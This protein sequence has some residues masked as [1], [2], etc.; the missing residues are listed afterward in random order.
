M[1]IEI[2]MPALSPTMTEGK[3]AKWLVKEGD[4][5][6]SGDVIAE[7][8]TDKA[9]MEVEAVDEGTVAKILVPEGTD[10]VAVNT[11]IA[12]V[13]GEGE[14]ASAAAAPKAAP[15][16]AP[17]PVA[18][19][20]VAAAAPAPAAASAPAPAGARVF[21]SPLAKR[22]AKDSGVDL[23]A[24]R[25]SGPHGRIVK[26]DVEAAAMAPKPAPAAVAAAAPVAAPAPAPKPAVFP[27]P[28]G[29][30]TSVP[31]D[32][33]RKTVAKRLTEAKSTI[34]HF[35]LTIDCELDELLALR[36][37]L[38]A[39]S[40]A[41]ISVNDFILRASALALKKVPAANATW[42]DDAI[43]RHKHADVAVAVAIDGGLITPIVFNAEAKGLAAIAAETKDLAERARS[44]KLKPAE[45]QGGTFSI[46]NL[47]MFGIKEFAAVI[48]P[49][50]GAI[51][52]IGAGEKRPVV[53][54]GALAVA[55]VMTVTLSCDHRVV[56]G[57][58]GAEF[59]AAFKGL[60][61]DPM[62]MML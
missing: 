28:E 44:R 14:D 6:K 53:K 45:Y 50:H 46:S 61:E 16:A 30:F 59:L 32:G 56:D 23:A 48:N 12:L 33:M 36:S 1:A 37:Q 24:V 41:K 20:P 4:T 60:I 31:N 13:A 49:P 62:T 19:A 10:N 3:L 25:G 21:A 47:G 29:S 17:A 38:N 52:A 15:A 7:I 51:L 27:F 35:Y 57:A 8:E 54:G 22:I 42:T 34:P 9:T 18:A 40:P 5:I 11:V 39:K 2:L 43:L 26:A 55:T 58:V